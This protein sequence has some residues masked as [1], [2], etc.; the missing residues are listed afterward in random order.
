MQEKDIRHWLAF[1]RV[2][3]LERFSLSGIFERFGSPA[4]IFAESR[5]GLELFSSEFAR[6]VKDFDSWGWVDKELRLIGDKGAEVITFCDPRYPPLLKRIYDPPCLLYVKGRP[7]DG[8]LPAVAIVGTRRPSHYG[9][10][11]AET[12]G[13]DLA[14]CGVT[15]VSGMAR[16]CDAAA[17]RGA[18]SA[19][20]FTVAVLGTGIDLAYPKE[21]AGLYDRIAAEG[22]LISE[23]PIST[24]P[25]P[26]NFPRRNRIISGL[27]HGVLVVEAPLRSGSLM[28]ARLALDYNREVFAVPGQAMS[29]KS[30]G[31]NSLIKDGAALIENAADVMEALSLIYEPPKEEGKG[32][33]PAFAADER[34]VWKT[35]AVDAIHI[36]DIAERTGFPVTK[37]SALL[38]GL[39]LRGLVGQMPGKCFIRKV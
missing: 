18:L 17:H 4:A 33:G 23:Y 13:R 24:P 22:L 14:S 5:A 8:S 6:V 1:S 15:V 30:A 21:N 35:L 37:V 29:P 31:G 25:V 7:Y 10:K 28:T 19:G 16:G 12:I 9:L 26:R 36:D 20:G 11:M 3:G 38:L 32:A 34:T 27:S 2:R 39:E